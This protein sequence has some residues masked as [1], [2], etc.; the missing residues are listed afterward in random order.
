MSDSE[1]SDSDVSDDL[2]QLVG[3]RNSFSISELYHENSKIAPS[4]SRI[5]QS[6]SALRAAANGFKRYR[7]ALHI[8]LP[9]VDQNEDQLSVFSAIVNR[10]SHREYSAKPLELKALSELAFYT[11]GMTRS[12]TNI[13]RCFPSAGGLY[14]LELYVISGNVDELP[15]GVY[16]YNPCTHTFAQIKQGDSR[17]QIQRMTFVGDAVQTVGVVFVFTAMFGRSKIKYGERAYRFA[18]LEAGHAMQ[19]VCLAAT[20]MG[21]GVCPVGGFVDDQM[22]DLLNVDGVEEAALYAAMIGVV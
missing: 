12:D 2:T 13:R 8:N 11:C 22:N 18:L 15:Q 6:E 20:A 17:P 21:L 3:A 1:H 4:G 14:P 10:R 7:H 19:N 16:H 5:V 9:S